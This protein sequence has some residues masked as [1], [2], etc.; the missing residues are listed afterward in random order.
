MM[1]VNTLGE[2][3]DADGYIIELGMHSTDHPAATFDEDEVRDRMGLGEWYV[4]TGDSAEEQELMLQVDKEIDHARLPA[5]L[6]LGSH[7]EDATDAVVIYLNEIEDAE[8]A[9]AALEEAI[10][11]LRDLS[12]ENSDGVDVS[13]LSDYLTTERV[14][15]AMGLS[16]DAIQ[17]IQFVHN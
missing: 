2:V 3:P 11:A 1:S 6:V 8:N 9:W 14:L 16:A 13:K 17:H 12:T 7:P 5:Y 4:R 10:G 15:F